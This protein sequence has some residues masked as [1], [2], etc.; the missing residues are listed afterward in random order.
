MRV[1]SRCRRNGRRPPGEPDGAFPF[2]GPAFLTTWGSEVRNRDGRTRCE[3]PSPVT[4]P[5]GF[6][7]KHGF[8]SKHVLYGPSV[9]RGCAVRR[10]SGIEGGRT[11][12]PKSDAHPAVPAITSRLACPPLD[13]IGWLFC[14]PVTASPAAVSHYFPLFLGGWGSWGGSGGDVQAPFAGNPG[15]VYKVPLLPGKCVKRSVRLLSRR[16]PGS[17]RLPQ[18]EHHAEKGERSTLRRS[19]RILLDSR[20]NWTYD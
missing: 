4:R 14:C 16:P 9:R 1:A 10:K 2:G 12:K 3:P 5:L 17:F 20:F 7:T 19:G 15:K 13:A 6:F 11:K 18:M 8:F